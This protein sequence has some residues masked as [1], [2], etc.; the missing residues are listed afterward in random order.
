MVYG[1]LGKY[2]MEIQIKTRM[3]T[4]WSKLINGK[5]KKY[6]KLLYDLG[7]K[8]QQEN[9]GNIGWFENIRSISNKQEIGDEFHY[10]LN[11]TSLQQE[12]VKYLT[13]SYEN[14]E[15]FSFKRIMAND[16]NCLLKNQ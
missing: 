3:I 15:C 5:D 10:I 11:C 9:R 14:K 8:S 6:A 2:P 12:R 4:Y 16:K 13:L 1:E 7:F